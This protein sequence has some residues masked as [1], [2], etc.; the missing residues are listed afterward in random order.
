MGYIMLGRGV[1][2]KTLE[3]LAGRRGGRPGQK[4]RRQTI[5]SKETYKS[6]TKM[7][8]PDEADSVTILCQIARSGIDQLL[9]K[10]PKTEAE[11]D[12]PFD[13]DP[14]NQSRAEQFTRI[15]GME[16]ETHTP[17]FVT[18]TGIWESGLDDPGRSW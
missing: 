9:P 2:S 16:K 11:A 15:K 5:E 12:K 13:I 14:W 6:R 18:E 17:D 1:T 10:A 4:G 7:G 8:S 3:Q